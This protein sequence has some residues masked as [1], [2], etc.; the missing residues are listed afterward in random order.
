VTLIGRNEKREGGDTASNHKQIKTANA[1]KN[2]GVFVYDEGGRDLWFE[3]N[4]L[5]VIRR[6][7]LQVFKSSDTMLLEVRQTLTKSTREVSVG[8]TGGLRLRNM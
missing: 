7:L 2:K 3:S 6:H 1:P 8:A 5:Q 4:R